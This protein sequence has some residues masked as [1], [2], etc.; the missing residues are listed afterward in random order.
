MSQ[1]MRCLVL[2]PTMSHFTYLFSFFQDSS[3]GTRIWWVAPLWGQ[4]PSQCWS[5]LETMQ[6]MTRNLKLQ[7]HGTVYA[8]TAVCNETTEDWRTDTKMTI[9][10]YSYW[11]IALPG[12]SSHHWSLSWDLVQWCW[13]TPK[14]SLDGWAGQ[15]L[16]VGAGP[17]VADV[18]V[19][20]ILK[21]Q[22]SLLLIYLMPSLH[23]CWQSIWVN[24]CKWTG[25]HNYDTSFICKYLP[26]YNLT[27]R[28]I[29]SI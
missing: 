18:L 28:V 20:P 10:L 4:Q 21:P 12:M 19:H 11:R 6:Q 27:I 25:H 17:E 2:V 29:L 9:L 26:T 23:I 3:T 16:T 1:T 14:L 8:D 22:G 24:G 5:L 7:S 15:T 13:L